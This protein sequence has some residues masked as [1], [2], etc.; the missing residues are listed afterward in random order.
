MKNL[1]IIDG[2]AGTGKTD[3]IKYINDK[4]NSNISYLKKYTTRIKRQEE[5]KLN[6]QLD[7]IHISESEFF[8]HQSN[9][10]FVSYKYGDEKN[11]YYDYGF[12]IK[13]LENAISKFNNIFVIIRNKPLVDEIISK[14]PELKIIV[15]YIHSDEGMVRNRL[16]KDGYNETAIVKR[17][18]RL[19]TAWDDYLK[20]NDVYREV[21]I[22]NSNK[23]DFQRLI[24][25][26][27]EKYNRDNSDLLEINNK[28]KYPLVEPLIGYKKK[29]IKKLEKYPFE[30]NVFLM[31]K[32]RESNK[33]I[34]DFIKKNLEK[35]GYNCVR[36]D[37]DDWDITGNI[38]NPIA[39]LY[40]CKF[41]IALFDEP[42][43][44]NSFSPNVAYELGI[45]HHQL[46][47]CLILRHSS[48]PQM[49]FDLIKDLHYKYSDNLEVEGLIM[50]WIKKLE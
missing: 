40:C 42:E 6:L 2:A 48:L 29:I 18:Q 50:K 33:L 27:I 35:N 32:F 47:N 14:F 39:V 49:P 20:H 30:K 28:H 21:I 15:V 19:N 34:Y 24:A 3:L 1:F 16:I 31:M 38:Y 4:Y 10:D 23:R 44:G 41:G 43:E 46:K 5:E 25:W 45:M 26:L 37:E 8:S 22:N 7:L 13:D 17:L 9:A 36:A 11:G 12:Y